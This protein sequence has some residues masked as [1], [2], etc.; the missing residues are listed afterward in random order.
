MRSASWR[1]AH[2]MSSL[3]GEQQQVAPTRPQADL[4]PEHL[5]TAHS[6]IHEAVISPL[7]IPV[8]PVRFNAR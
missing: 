3:M 1:A 8:R 6:Y 7:I 5:S 2:W 4:L